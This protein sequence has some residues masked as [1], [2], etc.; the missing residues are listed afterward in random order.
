MISV[1]SPFLV[2]ASSLQNQMLTLVAYVVVV[3]GEIRCDARLRPLVVEEVVESV[4]CL[5]LRF[6]VQYG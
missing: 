3:V 6:W 2:K 1:H 4:R 5:P